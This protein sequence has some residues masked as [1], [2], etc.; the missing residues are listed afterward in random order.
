M[1]SFGIGLPSFLPKPKASVPPSPASSAPVQ[2]GDRGF[3][4]KIPKE[5]P[6]AAGSRPLRAIAAL[7]IPDWV[8]L[9]PVPPLDPLSAEAIK[10]AEFE[11][12]APRS[13][14][15][16][17]RRNPVRFGAI[18]IIEMHARCWGGT[19]KKSVWTTK[20]WQEKAKG[21]PP[22]KEPAL[23]PKWEQFVACAVHNA[24]LC[25]IEAAFEATSLPEARRIMRETL[26]VAAYGAMIKAKEAEAA[27]K[28]SGYKRRFSELD[29]MVLD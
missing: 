27:L 18:S 21:F 7:A 28:A 10:E 20:Y 25:A 24:V 4:T 8:Y 17:R 12:I 16:R 11:V 3:K 22:P 9:P 1:V 23:K 15:K 14:K 5:R 26:G 29:Y 13:K 6:G 2:F 19:N